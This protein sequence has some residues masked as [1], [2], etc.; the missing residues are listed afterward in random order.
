MRGL[1]LIRVK[2]YDLLVFRVGVV[3][4]EDSNVGYGWWKQCVEVNNHGN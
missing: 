2:G 4:G 1:Q 3:W